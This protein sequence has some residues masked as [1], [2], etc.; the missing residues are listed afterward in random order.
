M[1]G[2]VL[3]EALLEITGGFLFFSSLWVS[4]PSRGQADSQSAKHAQHGQALGCARPA[5]V[6][7][8]GRIQSLVED[9]FDAPI[10]S[11]PLEEQLSRPDSRIGA[12][13][14][15]PGLPGSFAFAHRPTLELPD[16]GRGHKADLLRVSILEPELASFLPAAIELL[17]FGD[18]CRIPRGERRRFGEVPARFYGV[19]PGCF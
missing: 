15:G 3:A 12:G 17:A 6:F 14:E 9:A 8:Q 13:N 5:A 4:E 2:T 7:I 1:A 18:F 19:F 16:L 11:T 10:V